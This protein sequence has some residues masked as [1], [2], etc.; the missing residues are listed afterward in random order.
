MA[1]ND[2]TDALKHPHQ[3]VTFAQ[4]GDDTMT[5]LSQLATIFKDKFQKP[6]APELIQSPVK[7]AE[8]KKPSA[9]VQP[10]VI[11]PMKHNYQTRSQNA[12]PTYP[13]NVIQSQ[14]SPLLQR[15]VTP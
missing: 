10:I 15:V 5:A 1:A 3:D 7:A 8:N 9:L 2:I 11:P 12:S 13:S 14:N 4:V 6:S